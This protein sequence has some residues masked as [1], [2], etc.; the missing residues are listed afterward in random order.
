MRSKTSE[1]QQKTKGPKVTL[2]GKLKPHKQN[3]LAFCRRRHRLHTATPSNQNQRLGLPSSIHLPWKKKMVTP[4]TYNDHRAERN[5][6]T[7]E[8]DGEPTNDSA[9]KGKQVEGDKYT[10]SILERALHRIVCYP[11]SC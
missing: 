4:T 6:N 7:K 11:S 10:P 9:K 8:A 3:N 1:T 5:Q 2:V